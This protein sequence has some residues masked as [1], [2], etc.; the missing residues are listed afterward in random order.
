[1]TT[2]WNPSDKHS[3]QVLTNANLTVTGNTAGYTP[4]LVRA[5]NAVVSGE[6]KYWEV[7]YDQTSG[8]ASGMP[9][10]TD[11][12]D[13][14][15]NQ[16]GYSTHSFGIECDNGNGF[17]N[18]SS[19]VSSINVNP[20]SGYACFALDMVNKRLWVRSGSAGNWNNSGT[21]NPVTNTGGIDVSSISTTAIYPSASAD[22]NT[23]RLS[24][25]FLSTSWLGAAPSGFTE[26]NPAAAAQARSFGAI[27]G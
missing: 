15:A 9:G 21:A 18:G 2:T 12:T 17:L 6:K 5:V 26:I 19:V 25:R 7:V 23:D 8:T 16:N 11:G 4:G 10:V 3:S 13:A 22:T 1:M 20:P 14:V 27:L 24:A